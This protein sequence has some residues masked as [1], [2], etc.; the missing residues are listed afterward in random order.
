MAA[1]EARTGLIAERCQISSLRTSLT[2]SPDPRARTQIIR[3]GKAGAIGRLR[4]TPRTK[5]PSLRSIALGNSQ[6]RIPEGCREYLAGQLRVCG[7]LDG[8]SRA[9]L[10]RRLANAYHMAGRDNRSERTWKSDWQGHSAPS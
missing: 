9:A 2:T 7:T 1:F 6:S 3:Q 5:R 4:L 8:Q 10:F